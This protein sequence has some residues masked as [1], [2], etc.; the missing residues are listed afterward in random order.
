MTSNYRSDLKHD[1]KFKI[2]RNSGTLTFYVNA[3][4][5][6]KLYMEDMLGMGK[7]NEGKKRKSSTLSGF[8]PSDTMGK[9]TPLMPSID[10]CSQLFNGGGFHRRQQNSPMRPAAKRRFA[11]G[12]ATYSRMSPLT[13]SA[14]SDDE[15]N[16]QTT[17][18]KEV[19]RSRCFNILAALCDLILLLC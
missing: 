17:A 19:V 1:D 7:Q 13:K 14:W 18:P 16:I 2:S 12:K 9:K 8:R 5:K 3:T 6:V 15:N 11:Q 10:T 4:D